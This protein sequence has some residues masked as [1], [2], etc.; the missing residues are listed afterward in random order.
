MS[1]MCLHQWTDCKLISLLSN[2]PGRDGIRTMKRGETTAKGRHHYERLM[3]DVWPKMG[4]KSISYLWEYNLIYLSHQ[5]SQETYL[6]GF[7]DSL[8]P[9]WLKKKKCWRNIKASV[10]SSMRNWEWMRDE[11]YV[12]KKK[13]PSLKIL[14]HS[15]LSLTALI[16]FCWIIKRSHYN[17]ALQGFSPE[18]LCTHTFLTLQ[19]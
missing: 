19:A 14:V 1:P 2:S 4:N 10:H 18:T 6:W 12:E 8:W 5:F 15:P 13:C 7:S 3:R 11:W 17:T 16:V 9:C